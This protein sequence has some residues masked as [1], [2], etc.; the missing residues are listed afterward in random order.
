MNKFHVL[1]ETDS[2]PSSPHRQEALDAGRQLV[3]AAP[4]SWDP[5]PS[6]R[7]VIELDGNE[8]DALNRS[9]LTAMTLSPDHSPH[10][11]VMLDLLH[12]KELQPSML[13]LQACPFTME[14]SANIKA[15]DCSSMPYLFCQK[16]M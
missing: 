4:L 14:A 6:L 13:V 8:R 9:S 7:G 10:S 16:L 1:V 3:D 15:V 2:W 12:T 5:Q 11:A